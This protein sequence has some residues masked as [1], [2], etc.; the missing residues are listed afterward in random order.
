VLLDILDC[1]KNI[2]TLS[3]VP[4]PALSELAECATKKSFSKNCL[5]FCEGDPAGPLYIILS[6][7]VRVFLD[8]ESGKTVT[9]SIQKSGSYFGELSLLD[10][11]PRSASIVT[12][13]P[14]LCA[15]IPKKAFVAWLAA[16]PEDASLAVMRGLTRLIRSLT[17][18]VRGL[19]LS[20]VYTRLAKTLHELAVVQNDELL[21]LDKIS[22]QELANTIGS[23]REMVSKIMKDLTN[24][25]YLSIKGKVIRILKPLPANW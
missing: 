11:R 4:P 22:Q 19:A 6:G 2:P 8:S 20:D 1:L 7:K 13:E 16:N 21:I 24:G 17:D 10:D 23:S 25:G 14:T 15:M 12:L 3:E 5:I 18:N 9:L